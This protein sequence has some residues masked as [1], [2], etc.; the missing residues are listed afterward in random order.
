MSHLS[1]ITDL[2]RPAPLPTPAV[3][4]TLARIRRAEAEA[5]VDLVRDQQRRFMVI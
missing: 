1:S 4:G 3:L 5:A 2:L